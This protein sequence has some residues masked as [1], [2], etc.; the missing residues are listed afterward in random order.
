MA[1]SSGQ[2][3][4]RNVFVLDTSGSMGGMRC[5]T[6]RLSVTRIIEDIP[7]MSYVGVVLFDDRVHI[8]HK[9]IQITDQSVRDE[10]IY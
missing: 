2:T 4:G 6:L 3:Y 10:L 5:E 8:A 9:L 1:N 7:Q